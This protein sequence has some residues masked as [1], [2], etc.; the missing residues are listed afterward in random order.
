VAAALLFFSTFLGGLGDVLAVVLFTILFG[1]MQNL[2]RMLN[3]PL[4]AKIGQL[5]SENAAPTVDWEQV[6]RGQ[7][8]LGEPVGRWVLALVLYWTLAAA[9]FARRQLSY[10]QR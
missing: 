9:V 2:G 1:S 7:G 6:F 10:G 8:V 3:T 5:A 4:L